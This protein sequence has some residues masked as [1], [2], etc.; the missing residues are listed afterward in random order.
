[1]S[2]HRH[3]AFDEKADR[4]RH[5]LAALELDGAA[6][7]LLEDPR[8]RHEGLLPRRLVGAEWQVDHH[9]RVARPAHHRVAL[10]DHHVERHRNRGLQPVHHHAE[11][12][13][14]QDD[15]AVRIEDARRMG[16]VG[17]EHHDRG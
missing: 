10:Q 1:V 7:G 11:R 3:A 2:H 8:R 14:D 9:Q 13:P 16:M 15:I 5:T 6:A 12:I 4:L 17:R